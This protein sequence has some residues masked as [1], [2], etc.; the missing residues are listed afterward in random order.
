YYLND[1]RAFEAFMFSGG[2]AALLGTVVMPLGTRL[3]GKR[4]L[5]V[6]CM[7][8]AGLLT[9][10]YYF[11]PPDASAAI[12]GL[13]IAI[14]FLL[15]PTAPLI[16]VMFTD[17]ADYGE[18]KTGRRTTGLIMAAAMLSL[19]FGGAIGGFFNA[20]VLEIHGFVPNQAQSAESLQGIL[21]L[22]GIIPAVTALGAAALALL[23]P[24][25]DERMSEIE[26]ELGR[27]REAA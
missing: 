7:G 3:L 22:M 14:A 27:R 10:P 18:W 21:L 16:F 4:R 19:K 11:L 2:I 24:L 26:T 17:T 12:Y 13:N 8:S 15:G 23:Y 6:V 9:I 25:S 1:E 20:K 5:Y